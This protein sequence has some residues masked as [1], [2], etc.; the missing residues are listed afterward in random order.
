MT[1]AQQLTVSKYKLISAHLI[2]WQCNKLFLP[3]TH[4]LAPLS[5][6]KVVLCFC[7]PKTHI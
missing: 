2:D 7:L 4:N 5:L 3:T 6:I 1:Q